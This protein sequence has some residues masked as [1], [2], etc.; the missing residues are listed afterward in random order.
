MDALPA[1]PEGMLTDSH[2]EI[3]F[4]VRCKALPAQF[5]W[6]TYRP[7][8]KIPDNRMPANDF[9]PDTPDAA[10]SEAFIMHRHLCMDYFRLIFQITCFI[11]N[12][13]DFTWICSINI[14][15]DGPCIDLFKFTGF[16]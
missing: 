3:Q 10:D 16:V 4:A 5:T 15:T 9:Y 2:H 8:G 13:A 1:D 12:Q 6:I 14:T 11:G 7:H